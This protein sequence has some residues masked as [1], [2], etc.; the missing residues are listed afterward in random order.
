MHSSRRESLGRFWKLAPWFAGAAAILLLIAGIF[1]VYTGETSYRRG[2]LDETVVQ[3]RILA[4]TVIAPLTFDDRTAAETYVGALAANPAIEAAAVYDAEGQPFAI[5]RRSDQLAVPAPA[6]AEGAASGD[7]HISVTS[8]VLQGDKALGRVYVRVLL[9]RAGA[10]YERYAVIGLL[11]LMAGLMTIV[12]GIAQSALARS[13]GKLE[14]SNTELEAQIAEREKAEAALRQA[15][16]MEAIGQLTGGVAHDFNNIL[17]IILG[18]LASIERRLR[19]PGQ[20]KGASIERGILT[21]IRAGERAATLTA[22]L[23]AFSRR[24]PLEPKPLDVN[25]LIGGM[26]DLV[27]RAIG[28]GIEVQTVFGAR[29]WQALA[30][31]NQLENAILNLA[32]NARDAMPEGGKLTL[33]TA[34][35]YLDE[36][37]AAS[38][39][40]VRAGQFV[41]VAVSDT[42]TGMDAETIGKAF[43]PFFTT[44][45]I[46]QGTG[47]GLSQ[48]YGFI[49]QSG[50]HAKI[51]SE[52]GHGTTVKLYL[53]RLPSE[54]S[55]GEKAAQPSTAAKRGSETVLVVEDEAD[56]RQFAVDMLRELGY[57]VV[58]AGDGAAGLAVLDSRPDIKLLFTDVGLPGGFNG[59]Q[60]ADEAARR[61]P[62]IKTLYM[63]GYARN[64]IVHQ[65]RLDSGVALISKPFTYNELAARVRAVLDET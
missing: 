21:A 41:V 51:Y 18:N 39:E 36:A 53:P 37:Y 56:V 25:R 38:E 54:A 40:D 9:E 55:A 43:D 27:H 17:Q 42:G 49:K 58:E 3:A 63:T 16:K 52:L 23:L 11:V 65:G 45:D 14:A 60:L 24:Q 29:L 7:N 35:A 2:K 28:E 19:R 15:Q 62:T 8:P 46:G 33:E 13:Y 44:K 50:G 4:S 20:L 6:T 5:F 22:Q 10:R 57:D 12:L 26:S 30:D 31:A 61:L 32:V 1:V 34:N 59:R 64:A 48:V 47:L